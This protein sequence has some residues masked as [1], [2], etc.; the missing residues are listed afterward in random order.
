MRGGVTFP[1]LRPYQVLPSMTPAADSSAQRH[2][3]VDGTPRCGT[4]HHHPTLLVFAAAKIVELDDENARLRA[5]LARSE[6]R[7]TVVG[8]IRGVRLHSSESAP[9]WRVE[10]ERR[11]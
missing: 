7:R 1:L 9:T 6:V 2:G 3:H 5:E 8:R 4:H 10:M 11:V